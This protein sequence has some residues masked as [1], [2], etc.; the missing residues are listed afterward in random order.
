MIA[1]DQTLREML[2][3]AIAAAD[4]ARCVPPHLPPRPTG[5]TI[6]IGAGKA[7]ASM[8][9]AVEQNWQG[10]LTGLVV[11]R[12]GHAVRCERIKVVEAAHPVPDARGQQAAQAIFD[13]ARGAEKNDLVLCLIS[14]GG[15]GFPAGFTVRFL[16]RMA[17]GLGR[18]ESIILRRGIS[19]DCQIFPVCT[20]RAGFFFNR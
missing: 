20:S 6:V 13:L 18:R 17:N 10:P 9:R 8:A 4:P 12:Y 19:T 7:A 2:A 16:S 15:S 1:P 5:K 14:G 3:A 11:T